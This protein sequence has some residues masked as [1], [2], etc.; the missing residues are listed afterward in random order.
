[1]VSLHGGLP[2]MAANL[3]EAM[4]S[5]SSGK[6]RGIGLVNEGL[7]NNPV[8]NDFLGEMVWQ[9]E[10]PAIP[11][12]LRKHVEA[13]YGSCPPAADEAWRLLLA[14]VYRSPSD[15]GGAICTRPGWDGTAS[16]RIGPNHYDNSQ[17]ALAWQNLLD[18]ADQLGSIDTYRFDLAHV[19]RQV[20][21]NLANEFRRDA[22]AAY[23]R[24]DRR[25]LTD[26]GAHFGQLL[27]DVDELLAT[28]EE[29][30]LGQW[31]AAAKRW[32]TNDQQ[33]QLYEWN[34]RTIITL[35]G[36]QDCTL[37]DYANK[38]WAGM[39]TGFYL[40]RWEQFFKQVDTAMA[41]GKP[42]DGE[43]FQNALCD[44]ELQWTHR[45][46]PCPATPRG[47]TVAVS[48]R[49]FQKYGN[50]LGVPAPYTKP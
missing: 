13:R 32:A 8:V 26:A 23:H 41:E 20:L 17:L 12:W 16:D 50:L 36:P 35:W 21:A 31:L 9:T 33:R 15:A 28:R 45:N 47:N 2:Q 49:L 34:A 29:F 3:H 43:A 19:G 7:G 5:P 11:D 37:H 22:A 40:P 25:A 6:L 46:D 14:T 24:K 39:L 27:R 30:L 18:C 10:V 42:F 1:V 48:R 38:Q 44:W 4:T